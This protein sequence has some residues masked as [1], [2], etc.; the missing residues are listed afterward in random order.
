M[1]R[2]V[3]LPPTAPGALCLHSMPGWYEPFDRAGREIIRLDITRVV[4][5]TPL[6][7]VRGKSPAY[8]RAIE[9]GELPWTHQLFGIQD[10]GVPEDPIGFLD[11]AQAIAQALRSGERVLIHCGAGIGRTG[12]LATC[13]LM[14]LGVSRDD[15]TR[16]VAD[17]GAGAET[18]P[19]K[20]LVWWVADRLGLN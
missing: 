14:H 7:E 19:Q 16:S 18:A 11:L 1:F 15:A 20:A 2:S 17:A 10:Y 9:S 3:A 12:T 4:C 13:V 8:A 6:T 5:L